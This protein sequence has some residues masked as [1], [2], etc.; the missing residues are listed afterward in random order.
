[1][2]EILNES[3]QKEIKVF[4]REQKIN[5][6]ILLEDCKVNE[7][8]K[9]LIG[10]LKQ[11]INNYFNNLQTTNN[12]LLNGDCGVGK[13]YILN[14]FKNS[15]QQKI[16]YR[17]IFKTI[18]EDVE[19]CLLNENGKTRMCKQKYIFPDVI[20]DNVKVC[21]INIYDMVKD[22]RSVYNKQIPEHSYRE[23]FDLLILDELGIQYGTINEKQL[24]YEVVNY[25]YEN[26]LP[27]FCISNCKSLNEIG[28]LIGQRNFDR[29]I[30]SK[31]KIFR[32]NGNTWR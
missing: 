28:E 29:L 13:S 17:E 12:L 21:M 10:F 7:H 14:A 3:K 6:N 1:M 22:L 20:K 26:N 24:I 18:Y 9:E 32:L 23:E 30:N 5:K 2:N 4:R 19:I 11:Y 8:N 25:R 15:L 27:I 31:T 16:L